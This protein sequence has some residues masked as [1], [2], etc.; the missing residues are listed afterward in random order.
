[1]AVVTFLA[2]ILGGVVLLNF[3]FRIFV[4]NKEKNNNKYRKK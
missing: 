1:M 3:L 4:G 2:F